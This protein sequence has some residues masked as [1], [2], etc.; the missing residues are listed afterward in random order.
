MKRE[1]SLYLDL[2]RFLAAGTVFLQHFS[3]MHFSGGLFYQIEPYGAQAVI[4]FFVLSGYVIGH[5]TDRP[6][7]SGRCYALDRAA[8]IY[9]VVLPALVLT[10]A[11]DALGRAVRP[12][13]FLNGWYNGAEPLAAQ[14]LQAAFFVNQIWFVQMHPGT[15]VP[16]WS[17]GYEIWYYVIFGCMIFLSRRWAVISTLALLVMVG[18]RI[19]ALFPVWLAGL[20]AQRLSRRLGETSRSIGWLFFGGSF[21]VWASFEIVAHLLGMRRY[22]PDIPHQSRELWQDLLFGVFMLVHLFGLNSIAPAL[23]PVLEPLARPIRWLAGRSFALY[24]LQVPFLQFMLVLS[25]FPVDSWRG[26][27]LVVVGTLV[28]VVLVAEVTERRK[29]SWRQWFGVVAARLL[30]TGTA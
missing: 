15:N 3:W 21:L 10:F 14:F 5:V 13:L 6:G 17:M 20:A 25:P 28:L 1:V 9:S 4:V 12:A 23:G 26:R 19:A 16:Y 22:V 29:D 11:L 27:V 30:P 7:V 18:P 2:L 8:R 24:L